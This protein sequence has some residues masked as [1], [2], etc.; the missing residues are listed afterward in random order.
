MK[1]KALPLF[2]LVAGLLSPTVAS[3]ANVP[4]QTSSNLQPQMQISLEFPPAPSGPGATS[5]SGGATR[6]DENTVCTAGEIPVTALNPN[7]SD[8]EI[9]VSASPDLFVF[10]P[11]NTAKEGQFIMVNEEGEEVYLETFNLPKEAGIVQV[12]LPETVEL[13]VGQTYEWIFSL[14]CNPDDPSKVEFVQGK[15]K[16]T[17]L[18]EDLKTKIEAAREPLEQAKLYAQ[19][20]IWQD[21]LMILAQL[22]ESHSTEWEQFLQSVGLDATI[23]SVPLTPCCVEEE[24]IETE[25]NQEQTPDEPEQ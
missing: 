11:E 24:G 10:V 15:I 4:P 14:L 19:E 6:G 21:T 25:E 18:S 9:T 23:A 20:R 17:E 3:V 5:S 13:E 2:G 7:P 22:R 1:M 8:T 12:S 16:R